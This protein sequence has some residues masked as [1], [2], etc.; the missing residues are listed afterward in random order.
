[1]KKILLI[2]LLISSLGD[3]MSQCL[4][5][6]ETDPL[7]PSPAAST[8]PGLPP[9]YHTNTFDWLAQWFPV[10]SQYCFNIDPRGIESPFWHPSP[11]LDA[12]ERDA[13]SDFQPA[14]GWELVKRGMG[15]LMEPGQMTNPPTAST[16]G[17]TFNNPYLILYNRYRAELRVMAAL[18]FTNPNQQV[19]ITL[20]LEDQEASN[21][22]FTGYD[23]LNGLFSQT[24]AVAQPLDQ[25]T[26]VDR[27]VSATAYPDICNTFFFADFHVAYDPCICYFKSILE[28][29]FS[30]LETSQFSAT[31]KSVGV[32]H[33][34]ASAL[35]GGFDPREILADFWADK[36]TNTDPSAP[37]QDTLLAGTYIYTKSYQLY[38]AHMKKAE[39]EGKV[40][41]AGALY[42]LA[43]AAKVGVVLA[44]KGAAAPILA[45]SGSSATF[46]SIG[47]VATITAK[48]STVV[49][50]KKFSLAKA[51]KVAAPVFD[52]LSGQFK[53][54]KQPNDPE[55][56][57][58]AIESEIVLS[59]KV[60]KTTALETSTLRIGT[61]GALGNTT[62]PE[63][64]TSGSINKPAYPTYNEVLGVFS[65]LKTPEVELYKTSST[66][67]TTTVCQ[68]LPG[69]VLGYMDELHETF[70]FRLNAPIEYAINPAA[71][72]NLDET[73]IL[74]AL[75]IKMPEGP[76]VWQYDV[77]TSLENLRTPTDDNTYVSA[78]LPLSCLEEITV[79]VSRVHEGCEA[80]PN[81][82]TFSVNIMF[83]NRYFSE[84]PG[85]N[86]ERVQTMQVLTYPVSLT[87]AMS[88]IPL[89]ENI[90]FEVEIQGTQT[91]DIKAW[92]EIRIV[93]DISTSGSIQVIAG[94]KIDVSPDVDV[95][96]GFEFITSAGNLVN[97]GADNLPAT[98]SEI[99]T[100]C[101]STSSAYQAN[102]AA[103]KEQ[104]VA[105][106]KPSSVLE[107]KLEDLSIPLTAQPNPITDEL[108]LTYE[109]PAEAQ[110]QMQL[111]DMMGRPVRQILPTS[112]R[113]AGS[114]EMQVDLSELASG[115]YTVILQVGEI[116]QTVKVVK[117]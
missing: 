63:E 92:E 30:M 86:G 66:A 29:E 5:G 55:M 69:G 75:V 93:G 19:E 31:G 45:V 46:G 40:D 89:S 50:A 97:C 7:H 58:M 65:V 13:F 49:A 101:S 116:R 2:G 105:S 14:D 62:L 48:T 77:V 33:D 96:P 16:I 91:S 95:S 1:M 11:S 44:T 73:E 38:E 43:M 112:H 39:D 76:Q 25:L 41:L 34:L 115:M 15:Y 110:V 52:F 6:I 8:A 102:Q 42:F 83:L 103:R 74:A 68:E 72:L 47:T 54:E 82:S 3:L 106:P 51:L 57:P 109:L 70:T 64:E 104:F 107:E 94:A 20:I 21:P 10:P 79:K 18:P 90:P 22:D 35:N 36:V 88:P 117:R 56:F 78:F 100:F 27:V 26:Q 60:T 85:S 17:T 84:D 71:K 114:H 81:P 23:N 80:V 37:K 32:S 53:N 28:V 61:P 67:S 4:Q 24:S 98:S 111:V 12:I 9:A 99:A 59:G 113:K 108:T 87:T